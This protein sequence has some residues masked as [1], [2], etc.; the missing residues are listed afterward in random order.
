MEYDVVV[1]R[2]E[3]SDGATCYAAI[4]PS[5]GHGHGQGDTEEEALIDVADTIA[6]FLEHEPDRVKTGQAAEDALSR[7][8]AELEADGL[9]HWLKQVTPA[10]NWVPA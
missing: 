5:V 9:S 2:D 3:L 10:R 7:L 8:T 1:W 6:L 4:C